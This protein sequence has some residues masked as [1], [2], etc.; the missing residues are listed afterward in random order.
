[1]GT[2]KP[3]SNGPL[4]NNMVIGTLAVDGWA[5]RFRTAAKTGPGR[6]GAAQSPP[7]WTMMSPADQLTYRFDLWFVAGA[8][9]CLHH[10]S[11]I[12]TQP[13]R[14]N[15]DPVARSRLTDCK[16]GAP[17]KYPH[18]LVLIT[19]KQFKTILYCVV[20]LLNI[21]IDVYSPS[22]IWRRITVRKLG[23]C[24]FQCCNLKIF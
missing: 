20:W 21:Y 3:K 16:Q 13:E 17:K 15:E 5:V 24:K 23:P 22:F 19:H 6:A 10:S 11:P 18:N 1:M 7:L 2:L 8:V 9:V 4:Y 12:S 14:W